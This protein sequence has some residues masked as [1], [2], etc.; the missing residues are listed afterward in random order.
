MINIGKHEV[1]HKCPTC[2]FKM[3]FSLEQ[4]AKEIAVKCKKCN[5]SI[6][7][8]DAG[9]KTRKMIKDSNDAFKKL[10]KTMKNFGR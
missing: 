9:H 4:V 1:E 7:L 2:G 6:A 8:K 10:E 5:N 3:T